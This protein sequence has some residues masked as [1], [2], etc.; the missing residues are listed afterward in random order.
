[1]L[2]E[3]D[4]PPIF[5]KDSV[6]V[7]PY[8]D[9]GNIAAASRRLAATA[10]AGFLAELRLRSLAYHEVEEPSQVLPSGGA[11][12]DFASGHLPTQTFAHMASLPRPRPDHPDRRRD[13]ACM[14][15]ASWRVTPLATSCY[16]VQPS[17]P[18][19]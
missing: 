15:C 10:L 4:V 12:F 2:V 7:A 16:Y 13:T 9:N 8:V 17:R 3:N 11:I 19:T 14:S 18:W 1:M 5:T 6:V